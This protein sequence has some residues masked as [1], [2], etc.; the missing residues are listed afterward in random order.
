MLKFSFYLMKFPGGH[1][2]LI[3]IDQGLEVKQKVTAINKMLISIPLNVVTMGSFLNDKICFC[4]KYPFFL[5][6][7]RESLKGMC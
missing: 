3:P 5:P 6:F 7:V 4:R 2:R 1:S